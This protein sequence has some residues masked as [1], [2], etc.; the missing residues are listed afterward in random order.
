MTSALRP[1]MQRV[2]LDEDDAA[3]R[4]PRPV[5]AAAAACRCG[6]ARHLGRSSPRPCGRRLRV[7]ARRPRWPRRW[8]CRV[9]QRPRARRRCSAPPR[10]PGRSGR[11]GR[12]PASA[13]RRR[14][15]LR[16]AGPRRRRRRRG[17]AGR[18]RP[19]AGSSGWT[20]SPGHERWS[21]PLDDAARPGDRAVP[22]DR[23]ASSCAS[24][25]RRHPRTP[26]GSSRTTPT[27]DAPGAEVGV[28]V[29]AADRPGGRPRA[30][31]QRR[32]GL[33]GGDRAGGVG[34]RGGDVRVGHARRASSRPGHG[35][36]A[37][38]DPAVVDVPLGGQQPGQPGRR[39]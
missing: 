4:G 20:S 11:S 21:V 25:V 2:G 27:P 22:T 39:R 32:A 9:G 16:R 15:R 31:P 6:S 29:A 23:R 17:D 5:G 8:G 30:V 34:P 24:S 7:R 33:G 1:V 12:R 10:S 19:A 13:G 36:R 3:G 26:A 28:S 18:R 37:V 14:R 35:R 38:G